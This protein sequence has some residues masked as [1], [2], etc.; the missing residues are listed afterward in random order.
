MKTILYF[1]QLPQHITGF[2]FITLLKAKKYVWP[3]KDKN[4]NYWQFEQNNWFTRLV[5][6]FSLGQYI[7]LPLKSEKEKTI[8]H[9]YG[10]SIQS[11]YLGLFYL[12]LIGVPSVVFNNL[13][14]RAFHKN[15][16]TERRYKWYYNRYP[17]KWADKLGS[18][19]RFEKVLELF[20]NFSF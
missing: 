1:W 8:L 18:V 7:I 10:H 20:G 11:K 12:L 15:W 13:W 9:E 3:Y 17:E 5:S 4:I 16:S 19:K 6:G 14:D 2:L